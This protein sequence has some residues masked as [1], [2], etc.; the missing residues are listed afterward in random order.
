MPASRSEI[1]TIVRRFR[2]ILKAKGIN[3]ERIILFGSHASGTPSEY[4]DIDLV[5]ISRDFCTLTFEKRCAILGEAVAE[6]MEPIEPLAYTP[7]E[8]EKLPPLSFIAALARDPT[9]HMEL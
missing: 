3:P 5:V 2:S 6:T 9:R 8:F 1:E 7:E 4:S